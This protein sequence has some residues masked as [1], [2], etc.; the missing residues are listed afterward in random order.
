MSDAIQTFFSQATTQDHNLSPKQ[1][2]VLAASLELFAQKGYD[3]TSTADI[4]HRAGVSEGTIFK[5]FRT[6]EGLLQAVLGPFLNQVM[7]RAAD[8][9]VSDLAA[10]RF[11]HFQD[12]LT[13]A[14]QDRIRFVMENRAEMKIFIQEVGKNP[15]LLVTMTNMLADLLRDSLNDIFKVYQD[16]GELVRWESMRIMRYCTS[17]MIGY[18]IPNVIMDDQPVN[19]TQVTHDAVEF[20]CAGLTP[21]AK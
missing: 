13:Y 6:K 10:Q 11:P 2:A 15:E 12:L 7:P 4:A 5:R 20:L 3:A 8:A 16:K 21:Q 18:L 17:V 19:C 14:I 1:Q 9:F